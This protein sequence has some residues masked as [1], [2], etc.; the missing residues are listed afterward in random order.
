MA[1][2]LVVNDVTKPLDTSNWVNFDKK[3][4]AMTKAQREAMKNVENS[5]KNLTSPTDMDV[6]AAIQ[7]SIPWTEVKRTKENPEEKPA[8][9]KPNRE[10]QKANDGKLH[11]NNRNMEILSMKKVRMT[12]TIRQPADTTKEPFSPAKLHIDLLHEIHKFDESLIVANAEGNEK[13]NIESEMSEQKYKDTFKPLEKRVGKGSSTISIAHDIYLTAK[14]SEC[15]EAIFPFLKKNRIFI[16]FN[17]KPGLEHFAAIGVLFGPNPD[18][19]WRDQLADLLI[20]TMKPEINDEEKIKL[21]SASDGSPKVILSLNIQSIGISKPTEI[22]SVALEIRVPTGTERIYT[23]VIERLYEKAEKQEL[24][25]P[26]QLGKFFP[27]YMK[28]KKPEIFSFLMR[29]QNADMASTTAIPIFGYT[30]EAR[31][32][33]IEIDGEETTV[34]LALATTPS[35]IR[36]EATPSTWNIHKY[37]IIVKTTDKEAAQK[38][39]RKIFGKITNPLENQP[40]NFPVPRCGGRETDRG[41]SVESSIQETNISA[42]MSGLET[43]AAA[44]NPQE[45]GPSAPPKRYRKFTISYASA[46]KNGIL[47]Q[48]QQM[49]TSQNTEARTQATDTTHDSTNTTNSQR[50]VSW[51]EN[52]IDTNRSPGSSLSRSVTNSKLTNI[53]RDVDSEIKEI[54]TDME[55]RFQRQ[56]RQI[57]EIQDVILKNTEEM[58]SRIATA[59]ITALMRE[60]KNV[61][62]LIHGTT[63]DPKQAPLADETGKLPFGVQA[64]S[65]GPLDRLHHVE[66]T[67]HQM[68]AALDSIAEHLMNKDPTAK[69]LFEDDNSEEATLLADCDTFDSDIKMTVKDVSGAKRLHG[70]DRSPTRNGRQ[71]ELVNLTDESRSPQRSPPPKRERMDNRKPPANPDGSAREREAH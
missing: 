48:P 52:T 33:K 49:T 51:D 30:P 70:T 35:I 42:Y 7:E 19:T 8:A 45:A 22:S 40:A 23:A 21:G 39:I 58:E 50:Q 9:T 32:Q 64:R 59:V 13:I 41:Q 61:E 57:R 71:V 47:K 6:D 5:T 10:I 20:D 1:T 34:E 26:N 4:D 67:V 25:I 69:Y 14:A 66:I 44:D 24:M 18:V 68:A 36:I 12:I 65:G 60:R 28:S 38:D 37:L 3:K 11:E 2:V 54:K 55:Q 16:Y 15:K 27:Y 29:K 43:L 56:E 63:Y 31:N 53:H 46:T 17:P 62:E